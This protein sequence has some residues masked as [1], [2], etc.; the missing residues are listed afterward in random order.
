[1]QNCYNNIAQWLNDPTHIVNAFDL[2]YPIVRRAQIISQDPES[3][4]IRL[5]AFFTIADKFVEALRFASVNGRGSNVG[6]ISEA[7]SS[8]MRAGLL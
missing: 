7:Y 5:L 1:M 4:P 8:W 3:S 2:I 6:S